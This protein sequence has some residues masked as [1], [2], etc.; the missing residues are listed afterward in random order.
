M[1]WPMTESG[2]QS[3][4]LLSPPTIWSAIQGK[5][6]RNNAFMQALPFAILVFPNP[7]VE[8]AAIVV[9]DGITKDTME[10]L[11]CTCEEL[12]ERIIGPE[13]I[14]HPQHTGCVGIWTNYGGVI[15]LTIDGVPKGYCHPCISVAHS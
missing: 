10:F 1:P 12:Q 13:L 8:V 11:I 7:P 9:T 2:L 5:T 3:K 14:L 6:S 4:E 15:T